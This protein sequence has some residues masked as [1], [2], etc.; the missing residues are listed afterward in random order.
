MIENHAK[1]E[2][3]LQEAFEAKLTPSAS[4]EQTQIKTVKNPELTEIT[5]TRQVE[6]SKVQD[7]EEIIDTLGIEEEI[8]EY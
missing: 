5:E 7:G 1:S 4:Q 6:I 8:K 3:R 2:Q